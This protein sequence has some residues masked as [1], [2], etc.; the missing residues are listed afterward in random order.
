MAAAA[1]G[2]RKRLQVAGLSKPEASGE[3]KWIDVFAA[4]V[5]RLQADLQ[6]FFACPGVVT[7]FP[8]KTR[9]ADI[10]RK[11]YRPHPIARVSDRVCK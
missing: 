2:E 7:Q 8:N 3:Q 1:H 6:F 10:L 11:L 5:P 4:G 9:K